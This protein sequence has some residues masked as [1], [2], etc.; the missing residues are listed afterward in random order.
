MYLYQKK[1]EQ[2]LFR[3]EKLHFRLSSIIDTQSV[4]RVHARFGN[5][6]G[7]KAE[8]RDSTIVTEIWYMALNYGNPTLYGVVYAFEGSASLRNA[9][10]VS[11]KSSKGNIH[12]LSRIAHLDFKV[13]YHMMN[14][15]LR[16][17]AVG[18]GCGTKS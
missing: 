9:R 11:D 7:W 10:C 3:N 13:P 14:N 12:A 2:W 5:G 17:G 4:V 16:A 18:Y 8:V 1:I 15:C 6:Y